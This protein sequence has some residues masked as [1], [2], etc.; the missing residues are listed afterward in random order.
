MLETDSPYCEIRASHAGAKYVKT[1]FAKV[2]KEKYKLQAD[3]MNKDRNE[4][5]TMVQVLEVVAAV[6]G[7]SEE[8]LMARAWE[9]SCKVFGIK[10]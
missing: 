4:P 5:C 1:A 2:A 6:K 3:K 9:N 8:E 7:V 10:E